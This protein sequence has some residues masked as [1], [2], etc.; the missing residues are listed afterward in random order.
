MLNKLP[1]HVSVPVSLCL[2]E[3]VGQLAK[4]FTMDVKLVL[5][6][7]FLLR[8]V[9]HVLSTSLSNPSN[10]KIEDRL[11]EINNT[12]WTKSTAPP[13]SK[14]SQP[15]V[16]PSTMTIFIFVAFMVMLNCVCSLR[17]LI[18]LINRF[19]PTQRIAE[20][21]NPL[22]EIWNYCIFFFPCGFFLFLFCCLFFLFCSCLF[23][24]ID[25]LFFMYL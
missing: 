13:S 20:D 6:G 18:W 5:S 24:M 25:L 22:D 19:R 21:A 4:L 9:C 8:F 10:T 2:G 15:E 12:L 23:V 14:A 3:G 17:N 11:N 16:L 1:H 7:V